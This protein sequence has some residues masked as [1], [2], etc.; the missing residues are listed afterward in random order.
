MLEFFFDIRDYIC[1]SRKYFREQYRR[2]VERNSIHGNLREVERR[3][4]TIGYCS[5]RVGGEDEEIVRDSVLR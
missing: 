5:A 3:S 4:R 1:A 2:K